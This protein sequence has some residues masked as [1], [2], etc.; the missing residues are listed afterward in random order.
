M[1]ILSFIAAVTKR[2]A[3]IQVRGEGNV[4]NDHHLFTTQFGKG[5]LKG[6]VL[7]VRPPLSFSTWG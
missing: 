3:E 7:R 5:K 2:K 4:E 6:A 1:N